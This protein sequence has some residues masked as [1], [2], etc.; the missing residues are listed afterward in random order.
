SGPVGL[1]E[2]LDRGPGIPSKKRETIFQPFQR[3]ND[4]LA[5]GVSGSGLGLTLAR[6]MARAHGGDVTYSSRDGGGSCFTFRLSLSTT[7]R[8]KDTAQAAKPGK[9][10]T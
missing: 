2:V 6:R 7:D 8:Q 9:Q 4:S 10:S 1:V 5:S 3:L